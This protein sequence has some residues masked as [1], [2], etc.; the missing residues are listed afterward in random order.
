MPASYRKSGRRTFNR[1]FVFDKS[2]KRNSSAR[3]VLVKTIVTT[4]LAAKVAERYNAEVFDVLTGFKYIGDVIAKLE[5]KGEQNRFILGFEES[6]GYL[7]GTY[8]RDKDAVNA[9]MLIAE[10]TAHYKS[11]Q[12]SRGSPR[13]N[14]RSVR[15][16]RA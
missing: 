14:L 15:R 2:G 10:M 1:L 6:Y 3:P 5:R 4:A 12:N 7:S 11:G 13:R 16:L 8:V 9:S